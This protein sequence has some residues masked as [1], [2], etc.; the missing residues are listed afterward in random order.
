MAGSPGNRQM[1]RT[2]NTGS[3]A[4]EIE[5]L[6]YFGDRS[7]ITRYRKAMDLR[8]GTNP[9]QP[10]AFYVPVGARGL[11]LGGLHELKT[12]K[13]GMSATN[14]QDMNNALR[15]LKYFG[16]KACAIMKHILPCGF[17][18][19]APGR[20]RLADVYRTALDCDE[21]SAFGS[22][23]GFNRAV[24]RET[25]EAIMALF[26]EAVVAPEYEDGV[27][28]VFERAQRAGRGL[29]RDIRI[30][31]VSNM[32]GLP[33]FHGEGSA[34]RNFYALDDGSIITEEGYLSQ[35]RGREDLKVVTQRQPKEEEY[36]NMLL[37]WRLCEFVRS[38][39]VVA[40]KEGR[41]IAIGTG[42]TERV[43]AVEEMISTA[44]K[45][46]R[47][48][49]RKY[50]LA[51]PDKLDA[52]VQAVHGDLPGAAVAS[53]GFF[54]D[55]DSIEALAPQLVE[56]IIQPGGSIKDDEVIA[57]CNKYGITMAFTGSR[58]FAHL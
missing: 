45:K 22:V 27:L 35:V 3:F 13:G 23:V 43:G 26:T 25:A 15:I 8:Y 31:K 51:A 48:R 16:P 5:L 55:S 54:P 58:C 57:A 41:S 6:E 29:N 2:P 19:E 33:K 37:A 20:E 4:P 50:S 9:H 11:A 47:Y 56:A 53:D 30:V 18:T 40:A 38:N 44:Y 34:P 39:A 24:D 17:A 14:L 36:A 46:A 52:Y 1:Y 49:A 10:A 28:G 42:K 7:T 21:R 32:D 12:G